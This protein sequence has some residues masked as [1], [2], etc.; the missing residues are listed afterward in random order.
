VPTRDEQG[1]S[2]DEVASTMGK[3]ALAAGHQGLDT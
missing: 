2:F 3:V 1:E